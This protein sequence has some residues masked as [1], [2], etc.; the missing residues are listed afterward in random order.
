MLYVIKLTAY[1]PR[2]LI[3]NTITLGA[4]NACVNISTQE[5]WE[6]AYICQR[7]SGPGPESE[8][9]VRTRTQDPYLGDLQNLMWTFLSKDTYKIKFS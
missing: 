7:E 4:Q 5:H 9:G 3:F 8:F 1:K 2:R 6:S